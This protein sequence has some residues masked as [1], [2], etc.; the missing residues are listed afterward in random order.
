MKFTISFIDCKKVGSHQDPTELEE[1]CTVPEYCGSCVQQATSAAVS[2]LSLTP[3]E[4]S[5]TS[6]SGGEMNDL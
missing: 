5:A 2:R 6:H 1:G 4:K 3:N